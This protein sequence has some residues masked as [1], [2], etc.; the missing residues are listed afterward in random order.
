LTDAQIQAS[1]AVCPVAGLSFVG[2]DHLNAVVAPGHALIPANVVVTVDS[3]QSLTGLNP[4]QFADA[5][6][7]AVGRQPGFFSWGSLGHLTMNFPVPQIFLLPITLGPRLKTPHT[8]SFHIGMQ[9]EISGNLVVQADYYHRDIR[10]MLGVRT[11]NLAF[12]A[13]MPGHS[14][15]LQ[16]GTGN[17][18]ILSYGSWYQGRY[19]GVTIG[20]RR[21]MSKRFTLEAFY[22]WV[23]AVD[24]ALNSSFVSEVQSGRGAGFLGSYGPTDSFVGTVPMVTDPVTGR[25]NANGAFLAS[26]GNPVPQAGQFYNGADLD[27]GPSD[28]AYNHTMLMHGAVRLPGLLE[29]SGIFRVQSGFHFSTSAL[30]PVDVD[31]DGILNGVDLGERN[32]LEFLRQATE[33]SCKIPIILLTG[34]GDRQ[35]D[36]KAARAGASDYMY[37]GQITTSLLERSIRYAIENRKIMDSRDSALESVRL[38]SEFLANMSHEIRTPMN[39]VIG[40]TGLLLETDLSSRQRK[41]S[42]TIQSSAEALLTIIDDILD[43]SKIEAGLLRFEKIDFELRGAVEAS[44]E[45]LAE[46][47]QA[48]GLELASL[49]CRDVPT[50]LRG[51]PGRLRQVLTNLIGNA[52]KFTERGE[53]VVSVTKIS[54]TASDAMLR[55]EIQDSGIGISTESQLDYSG[56]SHKLMAPLHASMGGT[57]LGLAIS[58]QMVELMGG[59]IGIESTPG[60]G[61]IF[62]FTAKFEKQLTPATTAKQPAGNLSAARVL[63]V[64][65]NAANR[66]ILN[67]QTSSWGMIATEAESGKQALELLRAAVTQGEPYD[68]AVLDL[69]MPEMDGFQLAEVVK[70]DPTIASV[71]LVLL[72]S[73][74]ERG[75]GE[76]AR[77]TGIAAYLQKPVRQSQLY[78]CLTA[79]MAPSLSSEPVAVSR[80]ITR[81]SLHESEVQDKDKTF[82]SVRILLAEDNLVNQEVA[83]GQ[84]DNLGYRAEAV[85]NGRELLKALENDDVDIILMDCQMPEM[86]GCEA[87]AEI[88]RREGTARHTTIIAMTANALDGDNEKCLAAGMDD[89]L[90]K[91]V[92]SDVL[93]AKLERW[94]KPTNNVPI[95]KY[96]TVPATG[97]SRL[98]AIDL[99]R[100]AALRKIKGRGKGDFVTELIDM[101][102]KGTDSHAYQ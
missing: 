86:D 85:S 6:S 93:Q 4:Q 53:V 33:K 43:F 84:L 49:V 94:I 55:F 17:L 26:N 100:L 32:G 24:N 9:R 45:L 76:R 89:Y 91:P 48:K 97:K 95:G 35:V 69:M 16:P 41:Y 14:G 83:L 18:P 72:P 29:L 81:H 99:L 13:R 44:V 75:H 67:H 15:Q 31:G 102:I 38:K 47:A 80:L 21:R 11:S 12:E 50:S 40:M 64:D 54:E 42:E 8:R 88:R 57:G 20:M 37:K 2:I 68:I 28:L 59:E 39:G 71:A 1:G 3:V 5:A 77:R 65:D 101:F 36:L 98:S 58:K 34:A 74:G 23:N 62:W 63:I 27:R 52:V 61:S 10:D 66:S 46:R 56:P 60:A 19:D 92:K 25:T 51:D 87:T 78:D 79:V 73:F 70:S 90:G 30:R 7:T 22:S 82:S 96:F